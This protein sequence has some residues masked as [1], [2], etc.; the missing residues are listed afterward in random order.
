MIQTQQPVA[1]SA[2]LRKLSRSLA[3]QIVRRLQTEKHKLEEIA[4]LRADVE[5][6]TRAEL[7]ETDSGAILLLVA[8]EVSGAFGVRMNDVL[9][10][11]RYEI[12]AVPRNVVYYLMRRITDMTLEH[13]GSILDNRDHGTIL[14]G[15]QR[16]KGRMEVD[17]KFRIKV[18]AIER[19][20]AARLQQ[21]EEANWKKLLG[22]NVSASDR[23]RLEAA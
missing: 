22:R 20:C 7:L 15:E 9:G 12:F 19:L 6:L 16:V 23:N 21:R 3:D 18:E 17:E 10:R 14:N 8:E 5:R 2:E 1:V 4:K 11:R 13:I